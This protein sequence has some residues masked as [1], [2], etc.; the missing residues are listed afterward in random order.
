MLRTSTWLLAI[1]LACFWTPI[2]AQIT[3]VPIG[4]LTDSVRLHPK[5]SLILIS[6]DW[7]TYC[8][9]QKAQLK[10][11]KAFQSAAAFLYYSELDAESREEVTFNETT[12]SFNS[13]GVGTGSHELAHALG[14]INGRLAFPT[15]VL[16]DENLDILFQYPGVLNKELLEKL[17]EELRHYT[18]ATP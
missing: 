5:P 15:W 17:L 16:M 11:H 18:Y 2:K 12:Y 3:A 4:E 10:K 9:M 1:L 6:T 7:C 14:N 13:T 8:H